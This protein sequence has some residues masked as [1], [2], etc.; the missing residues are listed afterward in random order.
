MTDATPDDSRESREEVR[1]EGQPARPVEPVA[2]PQSAWTRAATVARAFVAVVDRLVTPER[3]G[4]LA[5]VVI[6]ATLGA[7]NV[8]IMKPYASGDEPR[9]TA[10]AVAIARDKKIPNV[11]ET[12]KP[13]SVFATNPGTQAAAAHPPLYYYIV[14]NIVEGAKNE[15]SMHARLY[16]A[17][18][19]TM[20]FGALSLVFV[21]GIVRLL[22]PKR[23]VLALST[24]A[25]LGTL[26]AF[27]NGSCVIGNDSLGTLTS[28]IAFYAAVRVLVRGPKPVGVA[29]ALLAIAFA[30]FS[31]FLG[32]VVAGPALLLVMLAMVLHT[33]GTLLRKLGWGA[34]VG[35]AGAALIALIDGWFYLRNYRLYGDVTASSAFLESF[36]RKP[37][38]SL[39]SVM[40]RPAPWG[41]FFV[42]LWTRLAGG[43]RMK[44]TMLELPWFGA[45]LP[46][47]GLPL[48]AWRAIKRFRWS[49]RGPRTYAGVAAAGVYLLVMVAMFAYYAKGGAMNARYAYSVLWVPALAMALG[50]NAFK[51]SIV[52]QVTATLSVFTAVLVH[53][54]YARRFAKRAN[55]DFAIVFALKSHGVHHPDLKLAIAVTLIAVCTAVLVVVIGRV[56]NDEEARP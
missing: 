4:L 39:L 52:P 41:Q 17:R 44:G 31:R 32:F 49:E 34:A 55:D 5:I 42:D 25:V 56:R 51:T 9:H 6:F 2:E 10:Y 15:K 3:W 1:A 27:I 13:K 11:R 7:L 50:A 22:A 18:L 53:E 46:L 21:F 35:A 28:C 33:Q 38:G 54:L 45:L 14:G 26:P 37:N 16:R 29:L 24:T 43:V 47:L 19:V 40:M 30:P 23:P 12:I 20:S 48:V 36:H 8:H